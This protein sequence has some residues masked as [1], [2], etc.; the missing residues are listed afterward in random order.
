M[1][2]KLKLKMKK[3]F[4]K[5]QKDQTK[6]SCREI[7]KESMTIKFNQKTNLKPNF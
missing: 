4:F 7:K 1:K 2:L 3:I 6:K 5:T